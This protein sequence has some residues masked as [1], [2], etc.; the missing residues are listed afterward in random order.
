MILKFAKKDSQ[1]I[2]GVACSK[3]LTLHTS[4]IKPNPDAGAATKLL[5]KKKPREKFEICLGLRDF[6]PKKGTFSWPLSG[7][8]SSNLTSFSLVSLMRKLG[9]NFGSAEIRSQRAPRG[10]QK[11]RAKNKIYSRVP[12]LEKE[13]QM[14]SPVSLC[15][16]IL[17]KIKRIYDFLCLSSASFSHWASPPS[18]PLW[19]KLSRHM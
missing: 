3:L 18:L 5:P 2:L 1:Y 10:D 7:W 9:R 16:E 15:C 13:N 6:Y 17:V 14:C 8:K 11:N 4:L 19:K 12:V